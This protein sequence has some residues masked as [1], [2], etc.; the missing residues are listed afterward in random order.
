MR[1]WILLYNAGSDNE[2]IYTRY[3]GGINKIVGFKSEDDAVRY[4]GLLEAQDF[5][6][7]MVEA[8]DEFEVQEFCRGAGLDLIVVGDTEL[9]MPPEQNI[10]LTDWQEESAPNESIEDSEFQ[11][12]ELD[13][14]RRRLEGLL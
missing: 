5:P 3:E 7:P 6:A 2:G 10:E 14:L 11:P 8:I 4:A 1:L 12:N 13:I 9:L